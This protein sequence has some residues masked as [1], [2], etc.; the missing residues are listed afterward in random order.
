V[1]RSVMALAVVVLSAC[2]SVQQMG[3][4]DQLTDQVRKAVG[5]HQVALAS[6]RIGMKIDSIAIA[7]T[8]ADVVWTESQATAVVQTKQHFTRSPAGQ[9]L[10]SGEAVEL[11]RNASAKQAARM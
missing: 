6:G 10:P 5:V 3:A 11:A 4:R 9:W 1:K 2:S 7:G 8:E